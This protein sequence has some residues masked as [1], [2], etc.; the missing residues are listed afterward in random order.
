MKPKF[1]SD[2][3]TAKQKCEMNG[4]IVS[5][6]LR[7]PKTWE[8]FKL[9]PKDIQ[10]EYLNKMS[11]AGYTR[12]YIIN[13]FGVGVDTY[14]SYIDR[15]HKGEKF[16]R[17]GKNMKKNND[18]VV[19]MWNRIEQLCRKNGKTKSSVGE[20]LGLSPTWVSMCKNRNAIPN[21]EKLIKIAEFLNTS[22]DYIVNGDSNMDNNKEDTIN[23]SSF[24]VTNIIMNSGSMEFIGTIKNICDFCNSMLNKNSKYKITFSFEEVA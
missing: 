18:N 20:M 19:L 14:E 9:M 10:S 17:N 1:P 5:Y 11:D 12:E 16:F 4:K 13:M 21:L 2:Y 23:Y 15:N 24:E 3:L 7:E 6:N 8:Q 22:V